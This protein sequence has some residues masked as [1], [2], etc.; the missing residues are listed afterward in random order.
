M[1]KLN[2]EMLNTMSRSRE[3]LSKPSSPPLM[4]PTVKT[5]PVK[6]PPI[7]SPRATRIPSIK[8]SNEFKK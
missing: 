1:A 4:S 3:I 5:P 2:Q 6:S 8:S 7:I